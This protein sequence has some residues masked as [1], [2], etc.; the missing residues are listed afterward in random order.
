[1]EKYHNKSSNIPKRETR[2]SFLY[3]EIYENKKETEN[4]I[5]LSDNARE[6]DI[7]Q[8]RQMLNDRENYKR[9][10]DYREII[11]EKEVFQDRKITYQ[12]PDEKDYDIN[13]IIKK[14]K[15]GLDAEEDRIRKISNT[16]YDILK[17]LSLR[18]KEV[19]DLEKENNTL[20]R[21]KTYEEEKTIDLFDNLKGEDTEDLT[22]AITRKEIEVKK[23]NLNTFE[24]EKGDFEDFDKKI[25]SFPFALKI[26]LIFFGSILLVSLIFFLLSKFMGS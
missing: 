12:E 22:P 16:Q 23:P 11:G 13:E 9:R 18:E 21:T 4:N 2:N 8:V 26:T 1:M 15:D 5:T 20:V 19:Y 7:N 14:K 6:I 3:D 24:F 10:K 17:G 25:S